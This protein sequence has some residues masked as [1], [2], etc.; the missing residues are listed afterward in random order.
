MADTRNLREGLAH[1]KMVLRMDFWSLELTHCLEQKFEK[2]SQE[3][4]TDSTSQVIKTIYSIWG[5][6]SIANSQ[7]GPDPQT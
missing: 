6:D 2:S 7:P 5:G 3:Q 4:P 1:T